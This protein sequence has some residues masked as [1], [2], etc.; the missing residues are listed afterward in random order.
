MTATLDDLQQLGARIKADR[1]QLKTDWQE[2]RLNALLAHEHGH[3]ETHIARALGIDRNTV[4]RW[5]G[6]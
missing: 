1:N 2:A 3:P 5:L 6:K 4:R